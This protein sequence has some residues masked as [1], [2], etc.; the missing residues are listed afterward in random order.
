MHN[1]VGSAWFF[2]EIQE[3]EDAEMHRVTLQH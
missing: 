3:L 1:F 2:C